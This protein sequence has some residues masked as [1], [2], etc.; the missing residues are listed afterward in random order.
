MGNRKLFSYNKTQNK[1]KQMAAKQAKQY[2][3]ANKAIKEEKEKRASLR[4]SYR[5]KIRNFYN[6]K[7]HLNTT[8]Q[9]FVELLISHF[10]KNDKKLANW[11]YMNK[12]N[13]YS[14]VTKLVDLRTK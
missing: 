4:F 7:K 3:G 11:I 10:R 2:K 6:P 5:D 12:N 14:F 8:P 13:Q 1:T 9:E